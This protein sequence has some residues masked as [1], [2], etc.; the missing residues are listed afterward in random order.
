[1]EGIVATLVQQI[2]SCKSVGQDDPFGGAKS[3][4]MTLS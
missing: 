3:K 2:T 1:M 4:E